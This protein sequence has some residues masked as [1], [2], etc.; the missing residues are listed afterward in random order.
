MRMPLLCLCLLL[1]CF[2]SLNAQSLRE[3]L[4]FTQSG[5]PSYAPSPID[6]T[7]IAR[8]DFIDFHILAAFL[9]PG[10][11]QVRVFADGRVERETSWCPLHPEDKTI[12][13]DPE[14]AKKLLIRARDGGFR[15]LCAT[16]TFVRWPGLNRD[17]NETSLTLSLQGQ[18]KTVLNS[19]GKPPAIYNELT[20]AIQRISPMEK[21]S[22]QH[23]TPERK[24]ECEAI[25]AK[26]M[27]HQ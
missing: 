12:Y 4:E 10:A 14:V 17:G 11:Y 5:C 8:T 22:Y 9:P 20:D 1:T 19:L 21:F 6:R 24:A 27:S 16:Y 23:F 13:V 3:L 26:R 2:A 25:R 7:A 18:S 15:Q